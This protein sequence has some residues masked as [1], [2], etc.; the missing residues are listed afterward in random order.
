MLEI[1]VIGSHFAAVLRPRL[2]YRYMWHVHY[3]SE[4]VCFRGV[5]ECA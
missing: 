4:D 3:S 2:R 1:A 5:V